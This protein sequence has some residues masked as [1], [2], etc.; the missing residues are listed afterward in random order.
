M[1]RSLVER[2]RMVKE[3]DELGLIRAAVRLGATLFDRALEVLGPGVK[4]AEV[5]AEMEYAARRAG[6]GGDVVPNNHCFRRAVGVAA[7][8]GHAASR[9]ARG[10]RGLRFRCYTRWLLFGPDP[11]C[12]GGPRS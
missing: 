3:V 1:R 2:A 5:A 7:R 9:R 10:I 6:S 12:V 4:E 11:H 8:Q